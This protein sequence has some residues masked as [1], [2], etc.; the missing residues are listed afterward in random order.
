M[1]ITITIIVAGFT[2]PQNPLNPKAVKPESLEFWDF[3]QASDAK[4]PVPGSV[5][6][7]FAHKMLLNTDPYGSNLKRKCRRKRTDPPLNIVK[8]SDVNDMIRV[9]QAERILT[10]GE[11]EQVR[12]LL[13]ELPPRLSPRTRQVESILG[14]P[15][16]PGTGIR[17]L[18]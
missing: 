16:L 15:R 7:I 8:V 17:R 13:T 4:L 14:G 12:G 1:S 18:Y 9:L 3:G 6:T 11:I 10:W 5:K 2:R